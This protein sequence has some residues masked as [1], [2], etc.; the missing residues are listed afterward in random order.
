MRKGIIFDLDGTLWDVSKIMYKSF[1]NKFEELGFTKPTY[2]KYKS[3]IGK[4]PKD[5]KD[6]FFPGISEEEKEKYWR[7]ILKDG[8]EYISQYGGIL[9]DGV[10]ET[11][12]ELSKDY[13]LY[14]VS[15]CDVGYIENFIEY[16][17]F[18]HLFDDHI[19]HGSTGLSKGENIIKCVRD[20]NLDK[21]FYVGDT[22]LDYLSAKSAGLEFVYASFGFGNVDS[23]VIELKEFSDLL[24][25]A[26]E[27]FENEDKKE[28]IRNYSSN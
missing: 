19:S 21:A 22:N 15:N 24:D 10:E 20:N 17:D 23:E 7:E 9:Y 11:L 5:F 6:T 26:E 4:T 28:N 13:F 16:Y 12:E 14:I 18:Y 8:D 27:I 2:E 1:D 25:I 3:L